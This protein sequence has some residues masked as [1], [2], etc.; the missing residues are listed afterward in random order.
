M[1]R[2]VHTMA[3]TPTNTTNAWDPEDYP[4]RFW[5]AN[6]PIT[7][8]EFRRIR[9]AQAVPLDPNDW[10]WE[11]VATHYSLDVLDW[12]ARMKD[13]LYR[14]SPRYQEDLRRV[15]AGLLDGITFQG[16]AIAAIAEM[17]RRDGL[18]GLR[19]YVAKRRLE[20]E[21][22]KWFH[23]EHFWFR[24]FLS[25]IMS[26]LTMA[27]FAFANYSPQLFPNHHAWP[28]PPAAIPYLLALFLLIALP[29]FWRIGYWQ[30]AGLTEY[31][32]GLA[33]GLCA[34]VVFWHH[35]LPLFSPYWS[36]TKAWGEALTGGALVAI[37]VSHHVYNA[38]QDGDFVN[39]V[40]LLI[41]AAPIVAILALI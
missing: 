18:D 25:F 36:P 39:L 41:V 5:P 32:I 40:A 14:Q 11:Y 28:P 24:L 10:D 8:E 26:A 21:R 37:W 2:E 29:Y 27:F 35:L 9:Y 13:W 12:A 6:A 16:G 19:A 31:A 34:A 38:G 17:I 22:D 4:E 1:I 7:V 15:R 3:T 20:S 33:A 30:S 23:W